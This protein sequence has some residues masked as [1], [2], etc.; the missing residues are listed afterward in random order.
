MIGEH[1]VDLVLR[2]R[3]QPNQHDPVTQQRAR[4]WRTGTRL[5]FVSKGRHALPFN[6]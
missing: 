2:R 3:A 1:R 6:S 4:S 5:V